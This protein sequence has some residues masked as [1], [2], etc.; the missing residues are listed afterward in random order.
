VAHVTHGK[1]PTWRATSAVL[2]DDQAGRLLVSELRLEL[3]AKCGEEFLAARKV[4]HRQ[5]DIELAIHFLPLLKVKGSYPLVE[6]QPRKSTT[7]KE[8]ANGKE[9]SKLPF[10]S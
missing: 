2:A 9:G 7:L 3:E 4:A 6:Q 10:S 1:S 5:V 8:S